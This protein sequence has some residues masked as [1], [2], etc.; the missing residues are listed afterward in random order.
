MTKKNGI[1]ANDDDDGKISVKDKLVSLSSSSA[2]Y[3]KRNQWRH[4]IYI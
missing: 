1:F 3:T 2:K 4:Q